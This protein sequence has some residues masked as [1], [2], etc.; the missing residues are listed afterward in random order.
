MNL[1][2]FIQDYFTET[3][4]PSVKEINKILKASKRAGGNIWQY[5]TRKLQKKLSAMIIREKMP[6]YDLMTEIMDI[7]LVNTHKEYE[8]QIFEFLVKGLQRSVSIEL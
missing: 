4:T 8:Q 2:A 5:D 1:R 3:R 6:V 7:V